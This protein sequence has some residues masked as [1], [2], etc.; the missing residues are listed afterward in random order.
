MGQEHRKVK[1]EL[2]STTGSYGSSDPKRDILPG[3]DEGMQSDKDLEDYM[4][5][6]SSNQLLLDELV[7]AGGNM[8]KTQQLLEKKG[9][10]LVDVPHAA[11]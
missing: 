7:S 5:W 6:K 11:T 4:R 10:L 8:D 9:D 2:S 3:K 1:N